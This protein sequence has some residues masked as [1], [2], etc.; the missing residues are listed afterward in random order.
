MPFNLFI[1]HFAFIPIC[2]HQN[3]SESYTPANGEN[4]TLRKWKWK[5][6]PTIEAKLS[7]ELRSTAYFT[8]DSNV[9]IIIILFFAFGFGRKK[10]SNFIVIFSIW[11][12]NVIFD[13]V[14]VVVRFKCNTKNL[15]HKFIGSTIHTQHT[16]TSNHSR[17][18]IRLILFSWRTI[19][20]FFS[21]TLNRIGFDF[22]VFVFL[23][24]FCAIG[25]SLFSFAVRTVHI[26]KWSW[27]IWR[28]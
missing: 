4:S 25:V 23:F 12:S 13:V 5:W 1:V 10:H 6:N 9:I 26:E 3:V 28:N 27:L 17:L 11:N 19:S 7:I 21:L 18:K 16:T 2:I 15:L 20:A 14:D 24:A 22:F 8:C